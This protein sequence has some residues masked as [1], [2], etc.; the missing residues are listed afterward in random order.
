[1]SPHAHTQRTTLKRLLG[2]TYPDCVGVSAVVQG[3]GEAVVME[4]DE[5]S[6]D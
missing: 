3:E 4:L 6:Q 5:E 2:V 1:M